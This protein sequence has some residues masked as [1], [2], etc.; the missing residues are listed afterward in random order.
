[1]LH[2]N[3]TQENICNFFIFMLKLPHK[4]AQYS[5]SKNDHTFISAARKPDECKGGRLGVGLWNHDL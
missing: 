2:M 5:V 1:M 4:R 3:G